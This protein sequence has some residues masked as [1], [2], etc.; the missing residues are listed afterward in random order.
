VKIQFQ[1]TRPPGFA[2]S[3]LTPREP[4]RIENEVPDFLKNWR[5]Q[6][7]PPP[8]PQ[9][10]KSTL[11]G[12][13]V[14]AVAG[15]VLGGLAQWGLQGIP[16]PD[17]AGIQMGVALLGFAGSGLVLGPKL[18]PNLDPTSATAMAGA[19][20]LGFCMTTVTAGLVWNGWAGAAAG[21]LVGAAVAFVG[22]LIAHD[23]SPKGDRP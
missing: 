22:G 10:W 8:G 14:G 5:E 3:R 2:W 17:L 1:P 15:G 19:A 12:A 6:D 4:E 13:A 20:G 18:E 9:V 23:S 7:P 11:R 21:T 16:I